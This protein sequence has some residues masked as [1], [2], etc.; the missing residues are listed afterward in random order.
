MP[1]LSTIAAAGIPSMINRAGPTGTSYT[2]PLGTSTWTCP[3]GV[4]MLKS[5]IG[6]GADGS[7][8]YW[9]SGWCGETYAQSDSL[10]GYQG[11]LNWATVYAAAAAK[12]DA[13]NATGSGTRTISTSVDVWL[14]GTNNQI[15]STFSN[16]IDVLVRGTG[17]LASMGGAPSAGWVSAP[18]YMQGWGITIEKYFTGSPG[19]NTTGFGKGFSGGAGDTAATLTSYTNI[20]VTPGTAYTIVNNG[21]LTIIY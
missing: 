11:Q 18:N 9:G 12:A 20:S 15:S 14:I 5:A 13:I 4:T 8:G 1:M 6:K 21:S 16:P 3:A 10:P 19:L 17:T 2:F 7:A